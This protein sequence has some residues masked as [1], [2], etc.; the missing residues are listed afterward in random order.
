MRSFIASLVCLL[1]VVGFA[2]GRYRL[3]T[4]RDVPQVNADWCWPLVRGTAK[5]PLLPWQ[6]LPTLGNSIVVDEPN[7][8]VDSRD[9]N[10]FP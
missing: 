6:K 7:S 10:A 9:P 2:M 4:P 1:L 5:R 3:A 8:F